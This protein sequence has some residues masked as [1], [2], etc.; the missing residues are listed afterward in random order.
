ML[1][2]Y[3]FSYWTFI[4]FILYILHVI[5]YS[6]KFI[7]IIEIIIISIL[8]F[9]PMTRYKLIKFIV[10]NI[11]IKVIPLFI[12]WKTKIVKRD[13]LFSFFI[14]VCYLLWL[15]LNDKTITNIYTMIYSHYVNGDEN[16]LIGGKIYDEIIRFF[17]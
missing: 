5:P 4:W 11:F 13:I 12:V 9:L 1:T 7:F 10:I 6:P 14:F 3:T 16:Q 8:C 17:I 2:S 15:Y